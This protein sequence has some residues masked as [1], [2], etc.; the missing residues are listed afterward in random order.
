MTLVS[1]SETDSPAATPTGVVFKGPTSPAQAQGKRLTSSPAQASG[2][3]ALNLD[4]MGG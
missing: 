1:P 4:E 2:Y 3:S